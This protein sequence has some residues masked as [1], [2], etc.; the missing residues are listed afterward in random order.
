MA[1]TLRSF[2]TPSPGRTTG[3]NAVVQSSLSFLQDLL[4]DYHPRNFAVQL[5]DGTRW[6]VDSGEASPC[7]I[8]FQHPGALRRVFWRADEATL[9]EAY[10]YDDVDLQGDLEAVFPLGDYLLDRKLTLAQRLRLG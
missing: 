5:W 10:V 7:T 6:E 2:R 9:G 1:G 3:S 8:V 4:R